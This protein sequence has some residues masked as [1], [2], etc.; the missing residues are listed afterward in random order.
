MRVKPL[1]TSGIWNA[2]LKAKGYKA[3]AICFDGT[4]SIIKPT[5]LDYA[6]GCAP[7]GACLLLSFLHDDPILLTDTP[8]DTARI[9][10][11]TG[12][13]TEFCD[14]LPGIFTQHMS[15]YQG[16]FVVVGAC[17]ANEPLFGAMNQ[18]K[19]I[20]DDEVIIAAAL[21]RTDSEI[22]KFRLSANASQKGF[23]AVVNTAAVGIAEYEVAAAAEYAM[24]L[25]GSDDNFI[26]LCSNKQNQLLHPPRD[27]KI[28]QGDTLLTE[29]GAGFDGFYLQVCRTVSIGEPSPSV[30]R[31]YELMKKSLESGLAQIRPGNTVG[32]VCSAM[33]DVMIEAGFEKY[34]YP[35]YM[36]VR[37]HTFH[38]ALVNMPGNVM[39]DNNSVIR[40]GAI[41]VLHPNQFFP[42]SGYLLL[43]D[44]FVVTK[45]GCE[46]LTPSDWG[47]V[48]I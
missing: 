37:G 46:S 21:A 29:M 10:E 1:V 19:A 9:N 27:R 42:D 33:D 45:T 13:R 35:P 3:S 22:A 6:L 39:V 43:G 30:V 24:Y 8:W 31:N 12:I 38:P 7:V 41:M 5:F 26:M 16:S 23:E 40:D 20:F 34:C 44:A 48:T 25:E 32:A 36:R 2:V 11:I 15:K 4:R 17:A 18:L 47:L 14:D 28:Q